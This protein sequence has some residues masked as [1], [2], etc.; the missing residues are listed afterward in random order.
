MYLCTKFNQIKH[1][2]MGKSI[3]KQTRKKT[4][5][6]VRYEQWINA[7]TGEVRDFAVV[8][9]AIQNDYG[10]HKVWIED[11]AMVLGVIGGQK[12]K[13]FGWILSHINPVSNEVSFTIE[14]LMSDMKEAGIKVGRNSVI[15]TIKALIQ[16]KFM[17]KV[18][19]CCYKVNPKLLVKGNSNKRGAM[20][21]IYDQIEEKQLPEQPTLNFEEVDNNA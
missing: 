7:T 19:I 2:S 17:K 14:E 4:E 6:T 8:D 12:I 10:F 21:I 18:R 16:A 20:M 1:Y 13:V 15:D 11:L 9:K 5:N 3:E